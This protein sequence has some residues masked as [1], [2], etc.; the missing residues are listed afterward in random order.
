MSINALCAAGH[1]RHR[2]RLYSAAVFFTALSRYCCVLHLRCRAIFLIIRVFNDILKVGY[3]PESLT[4]M[5]PARLI[6]D[7]VTWP[8]PN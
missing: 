6:L 2:F 1:S 4:R 8:I 3:F 7:S 5:R